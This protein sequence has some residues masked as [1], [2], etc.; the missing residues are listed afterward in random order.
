M[1]NPFTVKT[2]FFRMVL[3]II[4]IA[5]MCFAAET[6]PG[7]R[8]EREFR[9]LESS[10]NRFMHS[11]VL[12]APDLDSMNRALYG[13]IRENPGVKRIFRTNAGG[14]IVNDVS[15]GQTR[16]APS[17]DISAQRWLQ[18][19]TLS[20]SPYY[21]FDTDSTGAL[22][23]FYAWPVMSGPD[24]SHFSG[25]FAAKIDITTHIALIED[26]APFQVAFMGTAFFQHEWDEIDY[27]E[28]PLKIKG[29]SDV[30]IRTVRELVTRK[31]P[32]PA[33]AP[34]TAV[35][36]SA[37]YTASLSAD[38]ALM[39]P[40]AGEAVKNNTAVLLKSM[41]QLITIIV[42]MIVVIMLIVL[43]FRVKRRAES[44]TGRFFMGDA[45]K[46]S[47]PDG[48]DVQN[49]W[50]DAQEREPSTGIRLEL[51]DIDA[52]PPQPVVTNEAEEK[53]KTSHRNGSAEGRGKTVDPRDAA[54][55]QFLKGEF[56]K[57]EKNMRALSER[58]S[59]LERE[60]SKK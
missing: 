43:V 50:D 47:K 59:R 36:D 21:S 30:T 20:K 9:L 41:V 52:L 28:E 31:T 12:S 54:L 46:E 58:I 2:S 5:S 32:I 22:S 34:S 15:S 19:L 56:G 6:A 51:V 16:P 13:F 26:I 55:A 25:A 39:S 18:A 57:M 14:F 37:A 24:K 4:S 40:A 23:L 35:S 44:T 1:K 17:R 42:V 3:F 53:K 49:S 29:V 27:S 60:K 48:S 10:L 38:S 45:F 11:N 8:I 7:Q 33:P